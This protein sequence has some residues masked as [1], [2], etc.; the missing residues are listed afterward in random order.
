MIVAQ[1]SSFGGTLPPKIRKRLIYKRLFNQLASLKRQ[2][3][4]K[5]RFPFQAKILPAVN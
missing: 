4:H 3:C 5:N 2:V 1:S